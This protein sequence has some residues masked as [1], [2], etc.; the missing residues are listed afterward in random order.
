MRSHLLGFV[1]LL[2]ISIFQTTNG[3]TTMSEISRTNTQKNSVSI[4]E[5][6]SDETIGEPIG[7][8]FSAEL[9]K[10]LRDALSRK[11]SSYLP[12][13]ENLKKNGRPL[14]TN[15]LILEQ[16]P[17]LIQHAHNPVNW[18]SWGSEAFS[19]AKKQG[20]PIFCQL[21]IPPVIGVM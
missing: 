2:S 3:Q 10:K 7:I 5:I 19:A 12:R 6:A 11:G 15:R 18:Y 14:Y 9:K 20:K 17:Y 8:H 13:T 16:S 21:V 1:V 4:D